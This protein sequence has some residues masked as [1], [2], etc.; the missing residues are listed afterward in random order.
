MNNETD[1]VPKF[2]SIESKSLNDQLKYYK[3][4]LVFLELPEIREEYGKDYVQKEIKNT[5]EKFRDILQ[6]KEDDSIKEIK[7]VNKNKPD[8]IMIDIY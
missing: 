7:E 3:N 1:D 5:T 4:K 8:H 6:K 2:D